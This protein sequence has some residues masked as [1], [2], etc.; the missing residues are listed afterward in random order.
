MIY[1]EHS[2]AEAAGVQHEETIPLHAHT[3]PKS[4]RGENGRHAEQIS[5]LQELNN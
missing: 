4:G 3:S 2:S 5:G 1:I